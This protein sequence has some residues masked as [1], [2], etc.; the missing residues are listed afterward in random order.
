MLLAVATEERA[1][2]RSVRRSE[3]EALLTGRG[4]YAS[5]PALEGLAHL[6]VFRSP[7]GRARIDR[8]DLSAARAHPGVLAAWSAA[9]LPELAGDMEDPAPRHLAARSR[10]LLASREARYQGEALAVIAAETP[11]AA[12]DALE[13]V[14][15]ELEP[16]PA[17][18]TLDAA[19]AV[20]VG[21]GFGPKGELYP[22]ETLVALAAMRLGRPVR[23][24]ASRTEDTQGTAQGHG[25]RAE[26][27]VAAAADGTLRGIRGRFHTEAGAYTA[28]GAGLAELIM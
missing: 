6:A 3:D 15:A 28:A 10:P 14:E 16:L 22:E 8:L 9:D 27:E 25:T 17:A 7:F 18:A 12:A 5:D 13:L 11:Y 24:V 21:G 26:L 20:D 1:I 2:G 19:L 23:W 4:Q